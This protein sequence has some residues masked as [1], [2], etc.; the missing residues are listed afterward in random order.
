MSGVEVVED[1]GRRDEGELKRGRVTRRERKGR[2][3]Y[4]SLFVPQ[5]CVYGTYW[6][7]GEGI[8]R[9]MTKKGKERCEE[10]ESKK[11]FF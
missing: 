2:V 1:P 11:P 4:F 5:G 9:V 7:K 6:K 3:P 8:K 10:M